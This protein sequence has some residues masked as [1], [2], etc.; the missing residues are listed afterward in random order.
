MTAQIID[1]KS[2][3]KEVKAN[4]KSRVSEITP[5]LGRAPMLA[6]VLV[7]EDPA[8]QVYVR[9]KTKA[10]KACGMDV[11]DVKLSADISNTLLQEKL[12][13]LSSNPGVDGILLQLPLPKGLDEFLALQCIS[14]EKD[15]DGLHPVNQGL[16][17]R[18]AEGHRACTPL[19]AMLLIEKGRE[20][21]GKDKNLSGE[22]AVVVGRSILV[23]KPI[24][25]LL[26]ERHC[27]VTMCHSRTKDLNQ[28]VKRADIVVAAV[29]V[30]KL[31]NADAIKPGAIVIDVGINRLEDGTLVGDVDFESV[32]EVAGAITPVPGG[33]GPMT[34]AMLLANTVVSSQRS[35]ERAA[36]KKLL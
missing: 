4:L 5:K 31:I 30:P 32:S 17:V 36:S 22:H 8:S 12:S 34:I 10:A 27:T 13:E 20:L 28:E 18:G 6:V 26:L 33:A 11:T 14:P 24:A 19:G 25:M 3:A 15:V 1:G 9:S 35:S 2:L 23:G 7:G 29:G 21:L 16:L